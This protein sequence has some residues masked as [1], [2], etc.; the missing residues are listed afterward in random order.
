MLS[1][2]N[3]KE[4]SKRRERGWVRWGGGVGPDTFSWSLSD[5]TFGRRRRGIQQETESRNEKEE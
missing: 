5:G 2:V 4:K 1:A 3:H